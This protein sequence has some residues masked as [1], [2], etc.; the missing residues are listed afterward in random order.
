MQG[1]LH[2]RFLG[3]G[4]AATPSCYPVVFN[5][6]YGIVIMAISER[7]RQ[8][9]LEKNKKKRKLSKKAAINVAQLG[10]KAGSYAKYSIHECLAPTEL[11]ETGIG[12]IVVARKPPGGNVAVSAFILDVFC[13]GVKNALFSVMGEHDYEHR[14]KEG[15]AQSHEGRIFEE[16]HPSCA[17]KLV[18][19]AVFYAEELGFSPHRDYKISKGLLNEIDPKACPVKYVYGKDNKPFYI[20]GPHETP[21]QMKDIMD[22]LHRKCGEGGYDYMLSFRED[23]FDK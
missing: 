12:E 8:K 14:F 3:N 20:Q 5:E 9:K 4:T 15:L 18:E 2:M 1:N 23:F 11:F 22:K 19:G 7:Q 16:I 13:L 6:S 21:S 10:N 17:K